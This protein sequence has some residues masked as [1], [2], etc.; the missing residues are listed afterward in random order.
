[1]ILPAANASRARPD[2]IFVAEGGPGGSTT[3]SRDFWGFYSLASLNDTRDLVLI[4]QRGTGL[5]GAILCPDLQNGWNSAAELRRA[6]GRCGRTLGEDADRYG[7]GDIALDIEAVRR[8]LGYNRINYVAGSYGAVVEQAYAT[9]FPGHVR[10]MVIDAGLPAPDPQHRFNWGMDSA[11]A[12]VSTVVL[13]C[14]RAPAC[15]AEHPD[16]EALFDALAARLA[17]DPVSGRANDAFGNPRHITVDQTV[18]AWIVSWGGLNQGEV[19]AAADALLEHGDEAPLLR[20]GAESYFWPGDSGDPRFYSAGANSA[21]WCNDM[22]LGFDRT[23]PAAVRRAQFEASWAGLP[24][25]AFAPFTKDGWRGYWWPDA[26]TTWPSPDRYVPAVPAGPP[27]DVPVLLI[28]GDLDFVVPMAS[29]D[30]VATLF[31]DPVTVKLEGGGHINLG[32]SP[33]CAQ[34]LADRYI[35]TLRVGDT[36]CA[37]EPLPV[38]Q[39]VDRFP[40]TSHAALQANPRPGDDSTARDRRAAWSAVKTVLDSWFR[41]FR[42]PVPIAD[43]AGLR[44]GWFHYDFSGAEQAVLQMHHARFVQDIAV[45]GRT[46]FSFNFDDP[47]LLAHVFIHGRGTAKG[48]LRISSRYWFDTFF[49]PFL[50]RGQIGGREVLL[51]MPGN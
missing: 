9:R 51:R 48:E 6:N 43:G 28:E 23:A 31:A 14:Q 45:R 16:P 41:S 7:T 47:R 49:G 13:A 29:S 50:I 10:A 22:S 30:R 15:T 32:W 46:T 1:M 12:F 18:L 26:C 11:A 39:A 8:A 20:L 42:T 17:T 3:G 36:S 27:I 25:D 44:G 24:S 40:K 5:S 2:P 37:Q 19:A 34:V 38:F 4:D 33:V 35:R 21:T